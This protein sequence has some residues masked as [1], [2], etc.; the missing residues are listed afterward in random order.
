MNVEYSYKNGQYIPL[1]K[2]EPDIVFYEQPYGLSKI[3]EPEYVA[4]FALTAYVLYFLNSVYNK[5]PCFT[6]H[7]NLWKFFIDNNLNLESYEKYNKNVIKNSIATGYPK[8]DVYFENKDIDEKKYWKNPNKKK[9]VYAP[10][11]SFE[12]NGL[13]FATFQYNGKYI[14][15]WAKQQ[16]ETT[17][18]FKPH[19]RFKHAVIA[20][21]IMNEDEINNYYDEWA[22]IGNVYTQGDYFDIFKSS[23][24][25]I[26]DCVS[27]LGEYLPS[28]KP[29]I[30]LI[31][32]NSTPLNLLGRNIVDG[33]Y[34]VEN[35][36]QLDKILYELLI[37]NN[38]YKKYDRLKNIPLIMDKSEKVSVKIYKYLRKELLEKTKSYNN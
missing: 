30:R 24:L 4:D 11:H 20:N 2:F 9:I 5:T 21:N 16:P 18:V 6:F 22:K 26:T 12:K 23:D 29:L 31:N 10:H 28:E 8:L 38:D 32:K 27:F 33:Y 1:E 17:W 34:C 14:L 37:K 7:Q 35:S 15:E 13:N 36:E 19:P 3:Y 25:M